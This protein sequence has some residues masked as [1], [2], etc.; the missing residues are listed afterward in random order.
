MRRK[1]YQ[2]KSHED[3]EESTQQTGITFE[4]CAKTEEISH[5]STNESEIGVKDHPT[6]VK[7]EV[8]AMQK[9]P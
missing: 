7:E 6:Q 8:L 3:D 4:F 5:K 1:A 2:A 9:G